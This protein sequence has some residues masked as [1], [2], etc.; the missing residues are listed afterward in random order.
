MLSG[1][2]IGVVQRV[3]TEL[4]FPLSQV[5]SSCSPESKADYIRALQ[6]PERLSLWKKIIRKG[7]KD[8][9]LF[10][11]D[12]SNDAV[13]LAQADVGMSMC[14]ATDIAAGA[15]DVGILSDNLFSL[16]LF[17]TLS[18]RITRTI[19]INII[20]ALLYNIFAILLAGGA[21]EAVGVR[22]EPSYAGIGELVSVLPV[23][24]TS[25]IGV[26]YL[27]KTKFKST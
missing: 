16:P 20:W 14:Y 19:W 4:G 26:K 21:F 12:G 10:I 2:H 23:I 9:V 5:Q 25:V 18:R 11:G 6:T 24:I 3:A 15:A 17:L 13:A 8:K 22:I 7:A 27:G 1:D